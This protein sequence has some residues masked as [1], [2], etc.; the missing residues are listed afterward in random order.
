MGLLTT[1]FL[2]VLSLLEDIRGRCISVTTYY[3]LAARSALKGHDLL[4]ASLFS[5]RRSPAP[6]SPCAFY[7]PH[8]F[9]RAATFDLSRQEQY[10]QQFCKCF[11]RAPPKLLARRRPRQV[12]PNRQCAH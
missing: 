3:S 7:A 12:A 2:L 9:I 6:R 5:Y 10:V 1:R 11:A 4:L 8:R